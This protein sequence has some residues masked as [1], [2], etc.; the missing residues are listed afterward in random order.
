MLAF[1]SIT[2]SAA[3]RF[4]TI[5]RTSED[6]MSCLDTSETGWAVHKINTGITFKQSLTWKSDRWHKKE[7]DGQFN[8]GIHVNIKT[9]CRHTHYLSL[10]RSNHCDRSIH[11]IVSV[12]ST[13]GRQCSR[14]I[15][16]TPHVPAYR[17]TNW[18]GKLTA[19]C[20]RGATT[21]LFRL[22]LESEHCES[23]CFPN[24]TSIRSPCRHTNRVL[25]GGRDW[26]LE[27]STYHQQHKM[28]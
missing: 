7:P 16:V 26:M 22:P 18:A 14:H 6:F 25:L 21:R 4:R 13:P 28:H 17:E 11:F 3:K 5:V 10:Y 9:L 24:T 2:T 19:P 27:R 23:Q 1:L 15:Q 12:R 20:E 8:W